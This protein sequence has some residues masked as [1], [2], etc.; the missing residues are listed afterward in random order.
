MDET[1]PKHGIF[2]VLGYLLNRGL[3]PEEDTKCFRDV[4]HADLVTTFLDYLNAHRNLLGYC[5]LENRHA[6]NDRGVDI[7]LTTGKFPISYRAG[8]QIKSPLD[9]AD[10]KF[11]ANVKR[12][13]TEALSHGLDNY[14]ILI[15]CPLVDDNQDYRMKITH[16]L[17]E[18]AQIKNVSF[19]AFG[20]QHTATIFKQPSTV[21]REELLIQNII[22]GDYLHE[23]E[24][25]YESL[26]E[27]GSEEIQIAQQYYDSFDP[28]DIDNENMWKALV[29]LEEIIDQK[30]AEQF[31]KIFLPTLP[32]EVRKKREDLI[33]EILQLLSQCRAS[34]L[35]GED[36][37]GRLP[38][39]LDHVPE[40]MIPYT[41][42]QNLLRI[43]ENLKEYLKRHTE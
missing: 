33:A 40:Y 2:K 36:S 3:S 27:V 7:L 20:P 17:N 10:E 15:C 41:S 23:H 26:P 22:T 42:L 38:S 5:H 4:R 6:L 31:D 35:W 9:V 25:G 12:Q 43:C 21:S 28:G 30:Q 18:L 24:K 19:D 32:P 13:F 14:Y 1:T 39:W 37:G 16:L 34:T 29:V 11:S 8:F